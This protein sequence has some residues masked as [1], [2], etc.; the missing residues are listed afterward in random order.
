M[1]MIKQILFVDDDE[2]EPDIF[3]SALEETGIPFQ[4]TSVPGAAEAL[5]HLENYRPDFIIL[6]FNM[7]K[8]NGLELLRIIKADETLQDIPVVMYS[9]TMGNDLVKKAIEAG[10]FKCIQKPYHMADLPAVL[11]TFLS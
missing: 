6:D 1:P 3:I 8:I 11:K 2:D 4:C 9:A 5:R 10:A 7:P